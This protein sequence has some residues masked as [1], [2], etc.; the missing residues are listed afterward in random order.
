VRVR[1]RWGEGRGRVRNGLRVRVVAG[2]VEG[3]GNGVEGYG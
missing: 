1:L 2:R 3:W